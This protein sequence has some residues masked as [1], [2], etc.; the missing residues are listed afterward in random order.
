[1]V[2]AAFGQSGVVILGTEGFMHECQ[3]RRRGV[4]RVRKVKN[5]AIR[6]PSSFFSVFLLSFFPHSFT[7]S[8]NDCHE[9]KIGGL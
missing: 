7:Y 6:I 1:M 3:L 2:C 4:K 5:V 8:H 9:I